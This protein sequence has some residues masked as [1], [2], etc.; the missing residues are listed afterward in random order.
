MK[1]HLLIADSISAMVLLLLLYAAFSKLADYAAF[2]F[3]LERSPLLRPFAPSITWLLPAVEIT[4]AVLLF[5]PSTRSKGLYGALC[6]ISLF[7]VYL[8]AMLLFSPGLP[9]NCGGV[10]KSLSWPQHIFFN[11]FFILL[12]AI[13]ILLYKKHQQNIKRI[14][15]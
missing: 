8:A 2:K 15:P 9:C 11:L 6:L 10:L 5:I 7:T 13:G 3:S 12:S 14:P 1:K 4:I